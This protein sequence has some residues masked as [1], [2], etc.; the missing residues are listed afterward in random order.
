MEPI[1]TN[2]INNLGIIQGRLT[3]QNRYGPGCDEP[4]TQPHAGG[5]P[6][7]AINSGCLFNKADS[8]NESLNRLNSLPAYFTVNVNGISRRT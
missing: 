2:K 3:R 1:F 6:R 4:D 5:C 7:E 8:L